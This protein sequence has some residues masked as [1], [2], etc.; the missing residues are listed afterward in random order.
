MITITTEAVGERWNAKEQRHPSWAKQLTYTHTGLHVTNTQATKQYV[1]AVY[2]PI[3]VQL[4]YNSQSVCRSISPAEDFISYCTRWISNNLTSVSYQI[5][6]STFLKYSTPHRSLAQNVLLCW[7]LGTEWVME[8]ALSTAWMHITDADGG[9][10]VTKSLPHVDSVNSCMLMSTL[11]AQ[12][13][14]GD[15]PPTLIQQTPALRCNNTHTHT[16]TQPFYCWSGICPGLPGWAGTRKVKTRKVRS[17]WIY[18]SK[19]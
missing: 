12:W 5:G 14:T 3:N 10:P 11:H 15:S 18:W 7:I 9:R 16:H 2:R 6:G 19:R 1:H 8:L 4:V 17:I 13:P